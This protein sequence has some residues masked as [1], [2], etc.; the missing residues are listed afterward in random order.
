MNNLLPYPWHQSQW[1]LMQQYRKTGRIPHALLLHGLAET[2]KRQFAF[3]LAAALLCESNQA[4][5]CGQCHNCNLVVAGTHPD[6]VMLEPE[7]NGKAIKVDAVRAFSRSAS[8]T[9]QIGMRRICLIMPAE[10]MNQA[11]SNSLLKTLEEPSP[12]NHMLLVSDHPYFLSATIRS[13]CQSVE[14]SIPDKHV[15]EN[16]LTQQ[17]A[18]QSWAGILCE[19]DGAPLAALAFAGSG[20]QESYRRAKQEFIALLNGQSMPVH[21]ASFWSTLESSQIFDWLFRWTLEL[22]R[23]RVTEV[24]KIADQTLKNQI[25]RLIPALDSARL[26][27]MLDQISMLKQGVETRNLNPQMQLEQLAVSFSEMLHR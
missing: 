12:E 18:S 9:P 6:L 23:G 26:S 22:F 17:D 5:A 14:F 10:A 15:A 11:A 21:V 20:L 8:M 2:G 13:R 4:H 3:A 19:V 24:G 1:S 25:S 27:G 7:D 16:W